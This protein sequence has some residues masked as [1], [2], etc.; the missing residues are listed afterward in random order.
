MIPV[1]LLQG[2]IVFDA[3]GVPYAVYIVQSHQYSFQS[4]MRKI[5]NIERIAKALYKYTGDLYIYLLAKQFSADQIAEKMKKYSDNA[6]WVKEIE[7]TR[8]HFV[9]NMPFERVNYLVVP[10]KTKMSLFFDQD[11]SQ[12]IQEFL[13]NMWQG[14]VDVSQK[15]FKRLLSQDIE[16]NQSV[17]NKVQTMSDDLYK[18]QLGGFPGIRKASMREMEWWLKKGYYR[19]LP[20]PDL[21]L[22]EVFPTHIKTTQKESKVIPVRNSLLTLSKLSQEKLEYI[23]CYSDDMVGYSSFM[24]VLH[25]P[26]EI[27]ERDPTGDE[28]IF[29][30]VEKLEFPVDISI[31]LKVESYEVA[32]KQLKRRRKTTMQQ[33]RE[34]VGGQQDIPDEVVEDLSGIDQGLRKFREKKMP[35]LHATTII[36][37]GANSLEQLKARKK[38]LT[39][40]M[41]KFDCIITNS[42]GDQKRMFQSF[43]PFAK[44]SLPDRWQI[45]MDPGILGAAV[46]FGVRKMGDPSGFL[47]GSLTS[48]GR[49]VFMNPERPATELNQANTI[50]ICGKPGSGKTATVKFIT[51]ILMD[52]GAYGYIEDPKGDYDRYFEKPSIAANGRMV[53]FSP[54]SKINFNV[55]RLAEEETQR[56]NATI[57]ILDLLLNPKNDETRS[58]VIDIAMHMVFTGS[59]WDM[60][61]YIKAMEILLKTDEREDYRKHAD[62]CLGNLRRLQRNGIA[63]LMFGEDNGQNLFDRRLLLA[64]TRGLAIPNQ[65]LTKADWSEEQRV[66]AA[67]RY[68]TSTLALRRLMNLPKGV[69][70]FQVFEEFWILKKFPGGRQ[71]IEEALRFSRFENMVVILS[72]QNPTDSDEGDSDTDSG[73]ING[74]FSWKIMLRLDSKEQVAAALKLMNMNEDD[75]E[76]WMISFGKTYK[77]GMGLMQDPEGNIGE[78][79]VSF[80]D[81]ERLYYYGSSPKDTREKQNNGNQIA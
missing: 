45:P 79:K 27:S 71:L 72:T 9:R 18:H 14:I 40:I 41:D 56:N 80:V 62:A 59:K 5:S 58:F 63:A 69:L 15:P 37:V 51:D 16:I 19:G 24:P 54:G 13:R 78:I 77:D 55:F 65:T 64:I 42:P 49:P 44:G 20:D 46:P 2:N 28:W 17:I 68:G 10:L 12:F 21:Q 67:I 81:P 25:V 31:H 32:T 8:N 74:L 50:L 61:E 75:P 30:P 60:L 76:D 73:D 7:Y 26:A 52:W 11:R 34:W 48:N 29:G 36:A 66:A 47:F 4:T 1:A 23:R 3:D 22:P 35:L 53:S 57:T 43:Y 6:Q 38:E 33:M 70:K 39:D